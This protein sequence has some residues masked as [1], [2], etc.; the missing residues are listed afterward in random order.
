MRVLVTGASGLLGSHV[1]CRLLMDGHHVTAMVRPE[2]NISLLQSVLQQIQ[3]ESLHLH[4]LIP[5]QGLVDQADVVVHCAGLV[6]FSPHRKAQLYESNVKGTAV[7][8]HA[9]SQKPNKKLIHISSVAALG[10]A[11]G[12]SVIDENNQWEDNTENSYYASTKY[13]AELEVYRA[14]A[15]GL[16]AIVL[17]P[18]IIISPS[19]FDRSSGKL[20]GYV[21]NE[22]PFYP[23][24]LVNVV[25][26]RDVAE[27]VALCIK[28]RANTG[29]RYILN[30]HT[31][32]YRQL[33]N[34]LAKS[35]HKKP[36]S[37]ELKPWLVN[38]LWRM[39]RLRSLILKTDPLITK[40]TAKTAS[41]QYSYDGS[42]ICR[43]LGL[44]YCSF[45]DTLNFVSSSLVD[46][47]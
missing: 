28:N 9:L 12:L 19:D 7:I 33:L 44:Q 45:E 47:T 1:V 15:E 25:D 38:V 17:C 35:L 21:W 24:G 39:E 37:Y 23:K 41:S 3:L 27:A 42:K 5:L 36:P 30:A 14:I 26:V 2:S 34:A 29:A 11:P 6:S 40:E 4:D 13:W 43:E 32:S 20:I 18:S 10:R 22:N 31:M 8:C 16:Q 46:K